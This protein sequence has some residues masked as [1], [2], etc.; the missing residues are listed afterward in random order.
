MSPDQQLS[1]DCREW[2]RLAE[3]EGEAIRTQNWNLVAEC[4]KARQQLQPQLASHIRLVR[5]TWPQQVSQRAESET[6]LRAIISGLIEI[7]TQN[8]TLL[9]SLQQKAGASLL[10]LNRA[11]HTLRRVQSS[12][13][14]P[15]NAVWTSLS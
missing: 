15:Q 3:T 5:E 4:Q 13:A 10:Q 7:E 6:A 2:R 12:Y 14:Q 1:S 9:T 11:R 8:K